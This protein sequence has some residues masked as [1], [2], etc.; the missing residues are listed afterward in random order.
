MYDLENER[1][2]D[3][4]EDEDELNAADAGFLLSLH[5]FAGADYPAAAGG[6]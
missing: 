4:F 5:H 1:V 3:Y 6:L 2:I